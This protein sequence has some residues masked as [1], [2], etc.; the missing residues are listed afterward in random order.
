[1]TIVSPAHVALDDPSAAESATVGSKAAHLAQLRAAGFAVPDGIVLPSALLAGWRAGT[2]APQ[3]VERAVAEA[4]AAFAG[5][6]LAVRSSADAEDAAGASFAGSYATVLGVT[7]VERALAA[8]RTCLDSADAPRVSSYRGSGGVQMSVLVQP[9]L[10]P[11]AA[12]VAFTADPVSGA[13]DVVRI[14]AVRGLGD[15]LVDGS[16]NPE[17]WQVVAGA[18]DRLPG[19]ADPALSTDQVLA[20]AEVALRAAEHFGGPQD[21][22]WAWSAGEV[23]VLQSRPITTLPVPPAV[24]LDGLGWEKDVAHYPELFTPYGWS[25]FGPTVAAA[26]LP[27]ADNFGLMIDG[28]DQ[29]SIGGEIYVRPIPPFGSPEPQGPTPPAALVG[30]VARVHPKLRRRMRAARNALESGLPERTLAKWDESWRAEFEQRTTALLGEEL[31]GMD[32]AALVD[33]LERARALLEHGHYVHFQLLMPYTLAVHDLVTTCEHLLG[34]D[35]AKTL[36]LLVGYSPASVAGMRDLEEIRTRVAA[37]PDLTDALAASP[38]D[39]VTAL[40]PI[41]PAIADELGAWLHAHGWRT[42]NYDPGSAA[43]IERPGIV[44]RLLLQPTDRAEAT[45]AA[46]AEASA[47]DRLN[48]A[49]RARFAGALQRARRAYPV[50]EENVAL[51]D[52]VPCGILRRWVLEAGVRLVGRGRLPRVDDAVHC[53]ADEL[54]SALRGGDHDLA[55]AAARRRNEQAWVRAHPGPALVGSSGDLPDLRYLPRHGRQMNE[56]VLWGMAMEFPGEVVAGDGED[57]RGSP[58]SPGHYTGRVRIV[59]KEADFASLLPG[60]VLVCPTA[61]PSW[62]ILFG[63]AGALV[64]DGGG[65]LAHAAIVAREHSLPAV[66]GTVNAT[67]RL[68]DGQL[69]TID[70]TAGT[71]TIHPA[72]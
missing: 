17:E 26:G 12:G 10:D 66:V 46:D 6:A 29:V 8:V 13:A 4:V 35:T 2:A 27:M 24:T 58:A 33:H 62:T 16:A 22:E 53:T 51:T 57:L 60:E 71:V 30:L 49:D 52:N 69:V 63:I 70:G 23:H 48:G 67:S 19:D 40:R 32:D 11:E 5:R 72:D 55:P 1:M 44:T 68:T 59:R 38:A 41:D 7:G 37:R 21:I 3:E 9:M 39:P 45:V 56:A 43:I 47:L 34:W 18:A 28:I 31:T 42:T 20:V 14:S 65:P 61:S 36:Q 50:R 64:T 54:V 15:R 25:L